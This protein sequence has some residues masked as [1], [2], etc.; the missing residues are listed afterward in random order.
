LRARA[1]RSELSRRIVGLDIGA[2]RMKAGLV[3]VEARSVPKKQPPA[4]TE[5]SSVM[6]R[7]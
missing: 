4:S 5:R 6:T 2:T 3:D 1:Q 7:A